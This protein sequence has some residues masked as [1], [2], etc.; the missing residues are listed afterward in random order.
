MNGVKCSKFTCLLLGGLLLLRGQDT[1]GVGAITGNVVG[2]A[3]APA[4]AVRVC[5][6]TTTRCVA[7]DERG[8]FRLT[9][10]RVGD[11]QLQIAAPQLQPFTSAPV[12]VRA[13][14][15][16]Q[17]QITLPAL[18][19]VQQSITVSESVFVAP[20]EI[21]TSSF[22][23]ERE[24]IFKS[25]VAQMDVSRY[26][27]SLPGVGVGRSSM[28]NDLI[29]R[30]G[31]PLENLF[32][33]D[34]IEIPN[35]NTFANFA[36]A[37]G[38]TS[39][40]DADIIRDVNFMTGGYPAPFINRTSSVLQIAAREGSRDAFSARLSMSILTGGMIL[41][42]PLGRN[43]KG[44]WVTSVKRSFLEVVKSAFD[45]SP[46]VIYTFNT[47]ALYDLTPR[48]RIWLVNFSALD[49][50]HL[51]PK[52]DPKSTDPQSVDVNYKGRRFATGLN[53][54]HL[55][56]AHG[57]GLFGVSHSEAR[58]SQAVKDVGRYGL[59]V[60]ETPLLYR[61]NNHEGE[62]TLKYDLTT[63]LPLLGKTQVGGSF[64]T[65]RI[66]YNTAQPLGVDNAFS[67][68]RDINPFTLDRNFL[69]YQTGA[70]FQ[71]TRNLTN[72]LNLTWGG[73]FD[74][75]QV[76]N[77]NRFSPRVG[78]SYRLNDKLSLRASY[79]HYYQQPL[80]LLIESF[81]QNRRLTPIRANHIVAGLTYIFGPTVRMTV[82]A[83]QKDYR[84]YPVSLQ[85]P[86]FSLASAGDTFDVTEILM[87]YTSAGRGRARGIEFFL[88]KKFRGRWFAQTNLSISST[89]FSGLDGVRRPGTYDYPVV[90]NAVAGYKL[91]SKWD[92]SASFRAM[93]G[94]PYTPFNE[95]LST[96]QNREIYDLTRVNGLR[97]PAY[98]RPD[99]RFDRT[100]TVRNKP[101]LF[102]VGI[103]NVFDRRNVVGVR[104]NQNT[105]RSENFRQEGLFPLVGIDWKF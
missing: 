101:L 88:E 104:W 103:Q 46:P 60:S 26:V 27:Q 51:A 105:N 4:A 66:R 92:V 79:G 11:Y 82:E 53:W 31:S 43:K 62:T 5:V 52:L 34:N 23:V 61:E 96:A 41:E 49:G 13:G 2:K 70:Y 76:L 48:D 19:A 7:T 30:G 102:W 25:S 54:Q 8:A 83:Y 74:N 78:L 63:D 93:S 28:R 95:A 29:V 17:V 80:F 85:F 22:L 69:A 24:E 21:K 10:I 50:I 6:L 67:E 91:T 9:E 89:R 55:F 3:E 15:E 42:G 18:D 100:F 58:V 77:K 73:R 35:I 65:F 33:V 59:P 45:N 36:S 16:A 72:R 1:A 56:G 12:S 99:F 98:F 84:D 47:K 94:R 44:S 68:V 14:L 81:P 86:S 38:L 39:I 75:Y 97:A 32:V 37:G 71:S 20:E 87:P 90:F 64:K 57:V 40:L